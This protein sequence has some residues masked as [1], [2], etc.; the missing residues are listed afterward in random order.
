MA[1]GPNE[2]GGRHITRPLKIGDRVRYINNL[3]PS[4][5]N[6]KGTVQRILK[7]PL[8]TGIVYINFDRRPR[9]FGTYI[10][11]VELVQPSKLTLRRTQ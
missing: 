5:F 10:T 3:N 4:F 11:Y 2:A 1:S 7:D 6:L 8:S 9:P